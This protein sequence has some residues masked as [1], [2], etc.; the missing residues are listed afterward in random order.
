[1]NS[2]QRLKKKNEKLREEY[3][4]LFQKFV[5]VIRDP[6]S[7]ESLLISSE[8]DMQAR[9]ADSWMF[10]QR[11]GYTMLG[12]LEQITKSGDVDK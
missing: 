10:G 9:T 3:R 4:E 1:M 2:Y 11:K 12:L 6:N 8:I 7:T 5:K